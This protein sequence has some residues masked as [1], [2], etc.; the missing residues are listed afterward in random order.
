MKA[1]RGKF[2]IHKK[3]DDATADEELGRPSNNSSNANAKGIE[4][5]MTLENDEKM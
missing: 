2:N 1:K 3:N 5:Q 4:Q